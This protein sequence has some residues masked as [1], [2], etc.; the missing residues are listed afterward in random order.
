MFV[1]QPRLHW[2]FL[3]CKNGDRWQ[4]NN[5]Q[6]ICLYCS[7]WVWEGLWLQGEAA[8]QTHSFRDA[9]PHQVIP[10][11]AMKNHGIFLKHL[12]PDLSASLSTTHPCLLSTVWQW[13]VIC[14]YRIC[15]LRPKIRTEY[16]LLYVCLCLAVW[17]CIKMSSG[18]MVLMMLLQIGAKDLT[19]C[20]K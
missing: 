16:S 20:W 5:F 2:I 10:P 13:R 12:R 19:V 17:L 14:Y 9:E 15:Q 7:L 1:E 11:N 3:K 18:S 6:L 8:S 4:T